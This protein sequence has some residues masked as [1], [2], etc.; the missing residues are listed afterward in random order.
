MLKDNLDLDSLFAAFDYA[1]EPI[2]ITD[3]NL[4][5]G[6]KFIYVN[7]AFLRETGYTK[8]EL[9]GQNPKILQGKRSN[10]Q[11]LS[12]LKNALMQGENFKG[13]TINYKKDRTPYIVQWTISPL[14]DKTN[15]IIAYISIH[16]IMTAQVEAENKN[17]LF[18]KILQQ[19]PGAILVTDL[20]AN[21]V[22]VNNA[23]SHNL[24]Y[25]PNELIGKHTRILK[26]GKQ[27]DKF[28]ENMW[29]SLISE[30]KF[31]GIFIS[32]K[33]NGELFYDKKVIRVVKD[34][35]SN[36]LYYLAMCFDVTKVREALQKKTSVPN[37]S[38]LA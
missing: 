23:F 8:G 19:T 6:V 31:E 22:Y 21:I 29:I 11:M 27:N 35:N 24:G 17:I 38:K 2:A 3:A 16:K 15:N 7:Q 33:K 5:E 26:S 12:K 13:Q 1:I 25:E 20:E 37:P 18:D 32:K 34:H 9:I 30:H 10:I 28:Y 14:K 4:K 36:P